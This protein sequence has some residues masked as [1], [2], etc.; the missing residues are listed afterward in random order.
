MRAG[1]D[2]YGRSL[3]GHITFKKNHSTRN[4]RKFS[5]ETFTNP[6]TEPLTNACCIVT[7]VQGLFQLS[8]TRSNSD[9][10]TGDSPRRAHLRNSFTNIPRKSDFDA[11]IGFKNIDKRVTSL[12]T[13]DDFKNRPEVSY[14]FPPFRAF[15]LYL[16]I[17][18]PKVAGLA[19]S[20]RDIL[21]VFLG[22]ETQW[23]AV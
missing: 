8:P 9:E 3:G 2:G 17:G 5:E 1:N 19:H 12:V 20:R 6:E 15:L 22:F 23:A 16:K 11:P 13:L 14:E 21:N 18:P 4:L 10:T 7:V